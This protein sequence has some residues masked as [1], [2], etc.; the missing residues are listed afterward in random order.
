MVSIFSLFRV[1]LVIRLNSQ[2]ILTILTILYSLRISTWALSA[3]VVYLIADPK[4]CRYVCGKDVAEVFLD[5]D[6]ETRT[7]LD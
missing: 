4:E 3:E 7:I 1:D 5:R 2:N 6:S